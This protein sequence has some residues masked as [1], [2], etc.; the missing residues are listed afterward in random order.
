MFARNDACFWLTVGEV[1]AGVALVGEAVT[2]STAAALP[3]AMTPLLQPKQMARVV[4]TSVLFLA[5]A[6]PYRYKGTNRPCLLLHANIKMSPAWSVSE[7]QARGEQVK[8]M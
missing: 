2:S 3:V 5:M 7:N 4:G 1:G 6:K 8:R